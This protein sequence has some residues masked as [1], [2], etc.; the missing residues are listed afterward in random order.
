MVAEIAH[1]FLANANDVPA[2]ADEENRADYLTVLV[3]RAR[4]GD[5]LAFERIMLA[6]SIASGI[7][8]IRLKFS[9]VA[10]SIALRIA[11]AGPSIGNSPIPFAPDGPN[12]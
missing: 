12:A 9:P 3:T 5:A 2:P 6:T 10:F 1:V 8:G 4:A 11:G 7:S